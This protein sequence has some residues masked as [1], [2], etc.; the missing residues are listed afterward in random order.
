MKKIVK[1]TESDLKNIINKVIEEQGNSKVFNYAT[2]LRML[3]DNVKYDKCT[4]KRRGDN[5]DIVVY[6]LGKIFRIKSS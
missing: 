2:D 3:P 6:D 5:V 1:L 4:I